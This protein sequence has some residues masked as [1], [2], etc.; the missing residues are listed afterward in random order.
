METD[1]DAQSVWFHD[2][3][4]RMYKQLVRHLEI[5]SQIH[6]RDLRQDIDECI[7]DTF[8]LLW[9]KRLS[10]VHHPNIDGWLYRAA[11]NKFM[12]RGKRYR[13]YRKY[14]TAFHGNE[15]I[16]DDRGD[17]METLE[18]HMEEII[19]IVGQ[20]AYDLL[21]Q[22]YDSHLSNVDLAGKLGITHAALRM[23]IARII[24]PLRTLN[25]VIYLV[26]LR[27]IWHP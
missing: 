2:A 12:D 14:Y 8:V 21:L 1:A 7:Q 4:L 15:E 6:N 27:Y 19:E 23:R 13:V 17:A 11:L 26:L 9:Q 25:F 24:R 5:E 18:Q 10:L 20:E 3:Y 16:P 22:Y